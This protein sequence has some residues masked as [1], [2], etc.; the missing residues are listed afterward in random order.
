[1][2]GNA[3]DFTFTFVG[4]I[5]LN[6][7][8]PM[9]EKYLG[10]L[11]KGKEKFNWKDDG[12]RIDSGQVNNFFTTPMQAPKA[13]V[14]Y[15]FSGPMEY[16]LENSL[17]MSTLYQ[18]LNMRYLESVREEKG[19][20]Y[21]VSTYA[22]TDFAPVQEYLLQIM[23]D[24]DPAMADELM[25][26]IIDELEKIAAEGVRADDLA[27][28]KEYFAKQHPDDL[29]QNNYWQDII[30]GW[31]VDGFDMDNGYMDIVNGFTPEYF[32]GVAGKILSDGNRIT[33][34]MNPAE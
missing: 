12:V 21:G 9:V 19:G 25:E 31:H 24:T 4:N 10:S 32:K 23:F 13:T 5:D 28:V 15:V 17:A 14:F 33:I 34:V 18:V 8:K 11:P 27:K 22:V 2:A 26:I 30:S 16:N 3:D 29:K 6:T 7:F 1:M 20:T